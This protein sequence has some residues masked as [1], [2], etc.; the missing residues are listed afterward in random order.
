ML[1]TECD[2]ILTQERWELIT[3]KNFDGFTA[4]EDCE[5]M[6][7]ASEALAACD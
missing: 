3:S 6:V 7:L 4:C 5:E 2:E 1:C